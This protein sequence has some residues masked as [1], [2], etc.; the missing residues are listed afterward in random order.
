MRPTRRLTVVVSELSTVRMIDELSLQLSASARSMPVLR[1]RQRLDALAAIMH[2]HR[3][4]ARGVTPSK[5]PHATR[6]N[7]NELPISLQTALSFGVA[8]ISPSC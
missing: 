3:L 8:D 5:S 2:P 6:P 7:L 4:D 1:R